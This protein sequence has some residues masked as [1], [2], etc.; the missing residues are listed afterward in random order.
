MVLEIQ[1]MF[2]EV[3][4]MI[5]WDSREDS[6]FWDLYG[7]PTLCQGKWGWNLQDEIRPPWVQ[8]PLRKIATGHLLTLP[9]RTM[10]LQFSEKISQED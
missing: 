3:L 5:H 8:Q 10:A 7:P 4:D 1:M 6:I 9:V 2:L